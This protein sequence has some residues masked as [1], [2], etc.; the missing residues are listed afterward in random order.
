VFLFVV[1]VWIKCVRTLLPLYIKY[2]KCLKTKETYVEKWSCSCHAMKARRKSGG[3][4]PFIIDLLISIQ[5]LGR[6]WQEPEPSQ[7]TGMALA[8]W[9]LD[10]FLGVV[11][12]CFPLHLGVTTFATRGLNNASVPSSERWNWGREW[13]PVILPK[14]FLF[15]AI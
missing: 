7:A 3:S 4:A 15:Y 5:P 10:T 9:I 12:H 13:W 6:F 1:E 14:L 2:T 11:C 8:R